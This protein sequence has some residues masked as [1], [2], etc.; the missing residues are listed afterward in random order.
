[1]K[2]LHPKSVVFLENLPVLLNFLFG[3]LFALSAS[4]HKKTLKKA[5]LYYY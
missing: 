4:E 2:N 5:V 3:F 1:M